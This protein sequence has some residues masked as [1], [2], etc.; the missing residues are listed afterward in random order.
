MKLTKLLTSPIGFVLWL[1]L[2]AALTGCV[3]FVG[4]G[5]VGGPG[6]VDVGLPGPD[7][8]FGGYGRGRYDRDASHRGA[9]S[10]GGGGHAAPARGGGGG[11]RHR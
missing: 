5:Y 2:G 4:D 6:Y 8:V 7:F 11:G 10:R 3:G 1:V 9:V